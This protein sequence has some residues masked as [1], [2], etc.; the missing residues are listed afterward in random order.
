MA[1]CKAAECHLQKDGAGAAAA[2]DHGLV[3]RRDEE[4]GC[5]GPVLAVQGEARR[6]P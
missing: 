3:Y 6:V 4:A 2:D 5:T 1:W